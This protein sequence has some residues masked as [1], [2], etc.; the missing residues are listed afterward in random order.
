MLTLSEAAQR[1]GVS[2]DTLRWQ[3]HN[4][5]LKAKKVGPL[6]TVTEQE[7]AKYQLERLRGGTNNGPQWH[8]T[9][10]DGWK[11]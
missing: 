1:L 10:D 9:P 3:V 2:P 8:N 7:V 5:K 6:W 11:P 4:G